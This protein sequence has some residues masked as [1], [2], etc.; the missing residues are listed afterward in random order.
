MTFVFIRHGKK[1]W[2][3][4]SYESNK[5][6]VKTPHKDD[7]PLAEGENKIL[8]SLGE[9]LVKLYGPPDV[10]VSSP[11][12]R[13]RETAEYINPNLDKIPIE[14]NIN[15]SEYHGYKKEIKLDLDPSTE[16]YG[17]IIDKSM[18]NMKKRADEFLEILKTWSD[19]VV[20][21]VSH[22]VVINYMIK[23]LGHPAKYLKEGETKT[24]EV[25]A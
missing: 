22:R 11:Y 21:I 6:L 17:V 16:E 8:K 10:I 19:A 14:I 13:A 18:N 2:N 9:D 24:I 20:W 1:S 15:L 4:K 25:N 3:D 12:L 23:Q 7:P 5:N